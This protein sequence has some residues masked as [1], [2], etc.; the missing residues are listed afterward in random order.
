MDFY[1]PGSQD[2]VDELFDF[3]KENRPEV[4]SRQR[5]RRFVYPHNVFARP[6]YDGFLVSMSV[7]ESDHRLAKYTF[8][9][10]ARLRAEKVRK[11]FRLP[12]A[13]RLKTMGDC[14]A[15]GYRK[16]RAPPYSSDDAAGFYQDCGFDY[17]LSVDHL[18]PGYCEGFG[19]VS[20]EWRERYD[21][22]LQLAAEFWRT[23]RAL[24]CTFEP[25]GVAQG[26]SPDT[27]AEAI[28]VLQLIGYRYIAL[29]GLAALRTC[30]IVK[31]LDRAATVRLPETR[32][33]LLGVTRFEAG[34]RLGTLGVVSFD[35]T[36]PFREAVSRNPDNYWTGAR[37]Y[38]A[39]RVP[40]PDKSRRVLARINSGRLDEL[41]ARQLSSV[42]LRTLHAYDAGKASLTEAVRAV[43]E[44]EHLYD[45]GVVD[46]S[47]RYRELLERAPWKECGCPICRAI[48]IDVV[49]FR[50]SERNRRR[51]F[52]NLQ[53]FYASLR[54]ELVHSDAPLSSSTTYQMNKL[55]ALRERRHTMNSNSVLTLPA[56]EIQQTEKRKLYSF[57]VDGKLLREFATVS[58][59]RRTNGNALIG[60]QRPEVVAH[61][62][63][64]R[65]YLESADPLLPNA[66]VIAFDRTVRFVPNQAECSPNAR[67]GTLEIPIRVGQAEAEKPGLIVDGQQRSA[68]IRDADLDSFPICATAFIAGDEKEQREQFMLVNSTKPLSKS[69]LLELLP[70]TDGKLPSQLQRYKF[71]SVLLR[72]LNF[73]SDSPLRGKIRTETNPLGV[74]QDFGVLNMLGNS[75]RDGVLYWYRDLLSGET[76]LESM[77]AVLKNF[78]TAVARAFPEAW[79][80]PP[81]KSRLTH[82]AGVI[83]M[84]R[85]MDTISN[86]YR[87]A[88]IP[89][90]EMFRQDLMPLRPVCR[91]T[92]GYWEFGPGDRRKWNEVQNTSRDILTLS[93][94]L[95]V[96]YRT[97]VWSCS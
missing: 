93:R 64:I 26:W 70:E 59:I 45:D 31:C 78:W 95:I 27:Y 43:M 90:E 16:R 32:F 81:Q 92:E 47:E 29:G 21:M 44:Y 41:K 67:F 77:V 13:E 1:F 82:G 36:T 12:E 23:Y 88:G 56:L 4:E 25:V 60:Y 72:R 57:A 20:S 84:G 33:H 97:L 40:H 39:L 79:D 65:K 89:A 71:P 66:I 9:Q 68:A 14:G 91:W 76:D 8:G 69:L 61:I 49:I 73:D 37:N 6:P 48:G 28:R 80:L 2:F 74:L 46:R 51:G 24:S 52:H 62:E 22:T 87:E 18:V 19:D 30:E 34:A 15:F 10:A 7:V 83:G 94:F 3:E 75:L 38:I 5:D 58:R 86:R 63:E 96:N 11:F 54:Q 17:G 35:S 50:G 55:V 42:C 53:V 85:L